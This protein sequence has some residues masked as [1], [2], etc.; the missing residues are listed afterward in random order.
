MAFQGATAVVLAG[1]AGPASAADDYK[2]EAYSASYF[3]PT[4]YVLPGH[5]CFVRMLCQ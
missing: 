5:T 4:V 1:F 3:F 2:L